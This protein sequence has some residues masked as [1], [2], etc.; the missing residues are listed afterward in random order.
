[1]R[2]GRG[3]LHAKAGVGG[4][5]IHSSSAADELEAS[6]PGMKVFGGFGGFGVVL[7]VFGAS[8]PLDH[9]PARPRSA[10]P[11]RNRA[12]RQVFSV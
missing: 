5:G 7:G 11:R 2:R 6:G 3:G 12:A 9:P 8:K 10:T 4:P 1:M